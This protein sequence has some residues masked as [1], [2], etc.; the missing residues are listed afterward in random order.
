[1]VDGGEISRLSLRPGLTGLLLF[2]LGS[3]WMVSGLMVC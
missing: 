3:S 2:S 1:M